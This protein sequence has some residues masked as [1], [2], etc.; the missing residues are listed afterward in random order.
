L[1]SPNL[2]NE[3]ELVF[4][5]RHQ[6]GFT[7]KLYQLA[8]E[9]PG[10][11]VPVLVDGPYGGINLQRYYEGD[12][13]LVIA[14][15]SGAGWILP[16]IE[17]FVRSSISSDEEKCLNPTKKK[18]FLPV[19]GRQSGPLSLR[20]ILAT[21]DIGSRIWFLRTVT[22]LLSKYPAT[23][24]SAINIQVYLTGEAADSVDLSKQSSSKESTSSA[25]KNNIP[26]AGLQG[27]EIF[28]PGKEFEG[29][30][31][32]EVIVNEEASKVADAGESLSGFVCGP[33]TMLNDVRNAV[34][35]ENLDIVRGKKAGGVYL[36]AE[37]FSWA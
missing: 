27:R 24:S 14:G 33:T 37:H 19:A 11:S 17:Q 26:E 7:A 3:S 8:L 31:Q 21:R 36:H 1:P 28:V 29:R 16:F 15:G 12:R 22:E 34:A 30:P 10:V 6:K 25:D 9:Q 13:L 32:L 20:V 2:N 18:E 5:I 35:R 23:A 4:Y